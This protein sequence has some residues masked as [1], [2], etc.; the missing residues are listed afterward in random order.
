M[1]ARKSLAV[2]GRDLVARR[3]SA[4]VISH[5]CAS[6]KLAESNLPPPVTAQR[7]AHADPSGPGSGIARSLTTEP[8]SLPEARARNFPEFET[9][10]KHLC[11]RVYAA[12]AFVGNCIHVVC[13]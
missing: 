4:S 11:R 2:A 12:A 5:P 8:P 10:G 7:L 1:V 13:A 6:T 3:P 9:L